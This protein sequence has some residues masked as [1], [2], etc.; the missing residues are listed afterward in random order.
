M[1]GIEGIFGTHLNGLISPGVKH[2]HAVRR[3]GEEVRAQVCAADGVRL[4]LE[5][6]A[7]LRITAMIIRYSSRRRAHEIVEQA[8]SVVREEHFSLLLGV[9]LVAI[10][11][12]DSLSLLDPHA[13]R[14][15]CA[16]AD[17]ADV[18]AGTALVDVHQ[19]VLPFVPHKQQ[20]VQKLHAQHRVYE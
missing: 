17:L 4:P 9:V 13:K 20:G 10:A 2:L 18:L 1:S 12:A 15:R 16:F 3:E 5:V 8:L 14:L 7:F 19:A 11:V 6:L